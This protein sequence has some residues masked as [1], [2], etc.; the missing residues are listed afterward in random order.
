MGFRRFLLRGLDKVNSEWSL[1]CTAHNL[2]KLV[3]AI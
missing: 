2:R 3:Q 1:I